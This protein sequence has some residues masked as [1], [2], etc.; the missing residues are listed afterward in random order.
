MP[1]DSVYSGVVS[2]QGFRLVLAIAE[3]NGLETWATDIGKAYLEAET[4]EK[5]YIIAGPE[6]GPKREGHILIVRKALY[7]LHS[8]GKM[9]HAR[10]SDCL[11]E[12]GFV[13]C[14]A[15]PDIWLRRN[16]DVYEY[17]ATYV[18]DLTLALVNPKEFTD[19]LINKYNF[20]LKGTGPITFH[21]GMDFHRDEDRTLCIAPRKYIE[22]LVS[23]Y[24]RLFGRAPKQ[25]SSSPI[26]K[27]DHPELDDSE[28]LGEEDIK[29]YQ[30][31]IGS[32][33]WVVSIGR[34]D[35]M[36]A[37]M[38]LSGFRVAPRHG[39]LDRVC[40]IFGYLAKM[41]HAT[42]CIR[43]DEPDFSDVPLFEY[44]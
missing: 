6:F 25:T 22:K 21:L 13:P 1:I 34:F 12:L 3:L 7:G 28:L 24:E 39:H 30:S 17:V 37:I 14:K 29:K 11:R 41:K 38:T 19:I 18:D 15:E 5:V 35:V 4:S 9:W 33:Q 10:F 40:H 31:L 32:L 36:T 42:I 23:N 27:G 16:G 2:L 44:D 20:K 26:E 8:S 43:M